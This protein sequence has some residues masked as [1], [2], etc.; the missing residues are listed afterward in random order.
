MKA[1]VAV[2][3]EA[4]AQKGRAL[5]GRAFVAPRPISAEF[6]VEVPQFTAADPRKLS[7]A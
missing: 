7:R 6:A 1:F 5:F 4:P 2:I 3:V